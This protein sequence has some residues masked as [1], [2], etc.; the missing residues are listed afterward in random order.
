MEYEYYPR[1]ER[2]GGVWR[3]PNFDEREAHTASCFQS[4]RATAKKSAA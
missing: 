1:L 4:H 2:G 3:D